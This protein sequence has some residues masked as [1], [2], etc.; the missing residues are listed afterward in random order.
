MLC[1]RLTSP[2]LLARGT[3]AIGFGE[4]QQIWDGDEDV[5][6]PIKGTSPWRSDVLTEGDHIGVLVKNGRMSVFQNKHQVGWVRAP[7]GTS[8]RCS[9]SVSSI[10][11][12]VVI[13]YCFLCEFVLRTR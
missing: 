2:R 10:S 6:L 8:C 12:C 7:L 13:C 5:Y 4:D 1:S 9:G 3:W 11:T